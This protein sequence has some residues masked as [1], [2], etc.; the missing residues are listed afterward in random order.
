M[1]TL[2]YL[3]DAIGPRLTGSP[4]LKRAN[5]WTRDQ[6]ACWGLTNA[7]LEAWVRSGAVGLWNASPRK[8]SSTDHPADRISQRVVTGSISAGR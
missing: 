8:S 7:H 5:E 4:N 2:E 1:K 6:L 3:T